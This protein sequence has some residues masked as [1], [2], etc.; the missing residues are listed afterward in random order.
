MRIDAFVSK[1]DLVNQSELDKVRLLAFYHLRAG[2][3]VTE[4]TVLDVTTWFRN[5]GFAK[6][7]TSRLKQNIVKSPLFVRGQSPNA[8]RLAA[9]EIVKLENQFPDI[10][11][12]EEV[13]SFDTVLPASLYQVGREYI[14]S[15]GKQINAS[16]EHNIF[17]GCAVL[18]RRLL[19]ILLIHAYQHKGIQDRI[20]DQ[21]NN[22]FMLERIVADAVSNADL[23]LSRN[24]K[25]CLDK[26]RDLGNFSAHKIHYICKKQYIYEVIPEY[27][28]AVEELEYKAGL[29]K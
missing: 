20:K 25:P 21:G 4:F 24:T 10:A 16:Y 5:L 27:R 26:F 15:L 18:M 23:D 9:K 8:Y 22:Y 2:K 19:E 17:D 7:N 6:P 28:A 29:K 11:I 14:E 12:S 13:E 3:D 1:S